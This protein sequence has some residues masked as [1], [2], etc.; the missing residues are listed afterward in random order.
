MDR[1]DKL[2]T[3]VYRE[4]SWVP[5]N[6]RHERAAKFERLFRLKLP[7]W[8]MRNQTDYKDGGATAISFMLHQGHYI[9]VPTRDGLET[10][11][12]RL[13]GECYQVLLE[14]SHLGPFARVRFTRETFDRESGYLG[15]SERDTPYRDEDVLFNETLKGILED[16]GIRVL[17][18]DILNKVI[19]D[20]KLDVTEKGM[21]TIYHCLFD[22]E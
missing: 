11:I 12:S 16:E 13:G 22:E 5:W 17:G 8:P 9:G 10:R 18:R 6:N 3:K 14:I 4:R 1:I 21:A 2:I 19:P 7:D 20:I 15:Y